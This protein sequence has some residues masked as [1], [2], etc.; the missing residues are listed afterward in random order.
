MIHYNFAHRLYCNP[1]KLFLTKLNP[2]PN[3]QLC[4]LETTGTFVHMVWDCPGVRD[5]WSM[6]S[7]RMS[8]V[9]ERTIPCSP[10]ILLLNDFTGLDLSLMHQR[11]FLVGL[12]AAK[13]LIAQRWKAPHA[14]SY[15]HWVNTVIDLA[16]LEKSVASMHGAQAKNINLWSSFI[17]SM[18]GE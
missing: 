4:S 17:V 13:K 1:H 3:C 18:L 9:L 10:T 12:T 6:V 15:Q 11:W 14:L 16:K 8:I 2:S 7:N 5:F